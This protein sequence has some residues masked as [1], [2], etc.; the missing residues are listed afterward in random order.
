MTLARRPRL[1]HDAPMSHRRLVALSVLSLGVACGP[2]PVFDD[3]IGVEAIPIQAGAAAG[4]FA[5]KVTNTTL[6]KTPIG[7][8]AGGGLNYRLLTRTWDEAA[9]HYTQSSVLCG[10]FNFEV[11]GITTSLPE[12]SYRAVAPSTQEVVEIS[13]DGVFTQSGHLQL[14]GLRNLDDPFK[15]PLPADKDEAL[16]DSW[17][18]RVFD[19]DDDN[20]PGATTIVTGAVSG[21]V[22]IVQRKT[23]STAGVVLGPDHVVGLAKNTNEVVQLGNTNILLDRS[24]EGSAEAHPD[25]KRSWFEEARL[26]ATADCDDVMRAEDDGLLGVRPPFDV[27]TD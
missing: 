21:N 18:D 14:W 23:V 12:S 4:T 26:P 7:D 27:A 1:L 17:S 8:Y 22:Y 24:S 3:N 6:V 16:S 20:E 5:A 25:P 19:M 2:E 9:G 15:T 10:G 13:D 11:A